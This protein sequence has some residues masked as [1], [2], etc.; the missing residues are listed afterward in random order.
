MPDFVYIWDQ[1]LRNG[2]GA[3][4][5]PAT[6]RILPNAFARAALDDYIDS[7]QDTPAALY[8][9]M[10]SNQISVADWTLQMRDHIKDVN[11]NAAISAMGGRDQM[12]QADWGR[13]GQLIRRQ[14]E[15]LDK[16]ALQ[17]ANGLSI[18]GRILERMKM[19]TEAAVGTHERFTRLRMG[20]AGYDLERS[21]LD[22]SPKVRHC[23]G[24]GSCVEQ[25][26]RD[27]V[28]IDSDNPL[29]PIGRRICLSRDR[30]TKEYKDSVTGEMVQ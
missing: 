26:A 4:R 1:R 3:Y 9:L 19:Y 25:A 15:F 16:F 5:D 28:A 27:F 11:L 21:I 13:A 12:T 14:Y 6:G 30:C 22:P 29:I 24:A 20:N 17:I 18:D 23:T 8:N 10:R 2:A 7:A